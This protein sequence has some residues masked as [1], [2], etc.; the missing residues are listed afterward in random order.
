MP[1]EEGAPRRGRP[2]LVFDEV[3][4]GPMQILMQ[5]NGPDGAVLRGALENLASSPAHWLHAFFRDDRLECDDRER[6]VLVLGGSRHSFRAVFT[7]D[8]STTLHVQELTHANGRPILVE[9]F[10]PAPPIKRTCR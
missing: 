7:Y 4:R 10:P 2:R 8:Q 9:D 6:F 5:N 3:A 1:R